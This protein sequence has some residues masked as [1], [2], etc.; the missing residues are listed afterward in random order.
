MPSMISLLVGQS[1]FV[2][3]FLQQ[4]KVILNTVLILS[5]LPRPNQW[6]LNLFESTPLLLF[7]YET[8]ICFCSDISSS[9]YLHTYFSQ[10][11]PVSVCKPICSRDLPICTFQ[12]RG[13]VGSAGSAVLLQ[14]EATQVEGKIT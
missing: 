9:R 14:I 13:S 10:A 8:C 12:R 3:S 5:A 1:M 6:A 2:L 11:R 4:P 7:R